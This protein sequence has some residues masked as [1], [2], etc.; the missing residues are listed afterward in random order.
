MKFQNEMRK[1]VVAS[2]NI[3]IRV[4]LLKKHSVYQMPVWKLEN[5]KMCGHFVLAHVVYN[6]ILHGG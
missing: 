3:A 1:H 4:E 2:C 5:L 6:I